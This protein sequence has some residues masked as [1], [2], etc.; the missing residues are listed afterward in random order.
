MTHTEPGLT[1]LAMGIRAAITSPIAPRDLELP[2]PA[3]ERA[4]SLSRQIRRAKGRGWHLAADDLQGDLAYALARIRAELGFLEEQLKT[5]SNQVVSASEIYA[6]LKALGNEFKDWSFDLGH[7]S[8]AVTT[9][10]I[11]LQ[12]IYL[13]PF[14]IRLQ[15]TKAAPSYKVTALD[16]HPTSI[17]EEVT[18]PHVRD[19]EL[20]EG[21]G[22]EPICRA[23]AEGRLLD[24]F[25]LV[26]SILRSY[27]CESP[28]VALEDWFAQSCIDCET[29]ISG[30]DSCSC[31]QCESVLCD[32]C[33]V[34][35]S[36]CGD[37]FCSGCV[38]TC[39]SCHSQY[40]QRCLKRC[41]DCRAPHCAGCLNDEE[42]CPSCREQSCQDSDFEVLP[43]GLG[44]AALS[45]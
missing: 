24:F 43:G 27:N 15:W 28:F 9:E 3:W 8:L 20:C 31:L 22:R 40:C 5:S 14:E 12:G 25:L 21:E 35:C 6:D 36:E 33:Q 29:L 13:G 42:R 18:H 16:P 17:R 23:L 32:E 2:C 34:A 44:Q 10:P 4:T 30:D 26:R 7:R 37:S 1:R 11:E 45:A 19:E 39:S 38:S 41:D